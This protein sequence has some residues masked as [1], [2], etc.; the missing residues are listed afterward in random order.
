MN[1]EYPYSMY[2][3]SINL[4]HMGLQPQITLPRRWK[5]LTTRFEASG[6]RKYVEEYVEQ[7]SN[8][9]KSGQRDLSIRTIWD[10]EIPGLLAHIAVGTQGGLDILD[11]QDDEYVCY[12]PHNLGGEN[13]FYA[14]AI[15][16]EYVRH[17]I[18]SGE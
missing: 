11:K 5:D 12:T 7:L 16:L 9:L 8:L 3:P 13:G 6:R 4:G 14:M 10:V 15:A 1:S 18:Q 2:F 17:L